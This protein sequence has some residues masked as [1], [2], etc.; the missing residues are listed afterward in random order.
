[1]ESHYS[2]LNL[3]DNNDNDNNDENNEANDVEAA[4]RKRFCALQELMSTEELYIQDLSEIVNG[5]LAEI[6]N[7]DSDIPIPE[8]LKGKERI[9]FINIEQI[10][11]WHRDFFFK[12]LQRCSKTTS[13]LG[14]MIKKSE[15][16]FQMYHVYCQ[17]KPLSEHIVTENQIYFDQ[18]RQKLKHRLDLSDM[19]IKP[20][21]R[22]TKYE[23]LLKEITKQTERA[24]MVED[25]PSMREAY[26]VMKVVCKTI[27]AMMDVRRLQNFEGKIPAQG[28]LFMHGSLLCI[29]DLQNF[30]RNASFVQKAREL[31]VFLF[32]Q[33]IIFSEIVGKRTQFTPPTYNY[34]SL[35]QVNKMS[36]EELPN[37]R[38]LLK[39][40]DPNRPDVSF[41]CFAPSVEQNREW[42][43][44]LRNILKA[45]HDFLK[46]IINP[47]E[48]QKQ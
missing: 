35:I 1:L 29:D 18:I 20:V 33:S 10:Y 27:N 46:A 32:E 47:I 24:G 45:Q 43:E 28:K 6:R 4:Q 15:R 7:K 48:H 44:T 39:S 17:Q 9:V 36:L 26:N 31:Q 8:V 38:F 14:S 37:N 13:E 34:R 5:Y 42:I 19:L 25:V 3:N 41:V 12:S 16:K 21:Q 23:L 2:K 40:T 11:E 22:I 30:D